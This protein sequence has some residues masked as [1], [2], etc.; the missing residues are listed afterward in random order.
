MTYKV[1]CTDGLSKR[2]VERLSKFAG[3][4]TDFRPKLTHEEL[5]DAIPA[6]DGLIVRSASKV[7]SDVIER[8]GKLKI[9]A[10]AGVG[11][12]NID[13]K[14]ATERGILVVNTPAGNTTATCELTF[15]MMLSLA[16]HVPQAAKLMTEGVWEKKKFMGT[17]L[18]RKTLGIVGMGRI[19]KEVA[20]RAKAF[21]MKI[22]A[23]D[24]YLTDDA[25]ASLGVEK[26]G[27]ERILKE[28]DY[29]TVHT[30][31]TDETRN[32]IGA[33]QFAMMK[34]TAYVVNCARGGIINERDLAEALRSNT[35]AGAALDVYTK[36]PYEDTIFRGLDNA[37]LTPHLGASTREAQD[38][39]AV[40]AAEAVGGYLTKG[41]RM[42]AVNPQVPERRA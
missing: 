30:P 18:S 2:G 8:A 24:P 20:R 13:V 37:I 17:E 32:L 41:T 14:A 31:L 16:R 15:T 21:D 10:R 40:E 9:V 36:E 25:Y 3:V 26:A 27:L 11:V 35:I 42:N 4:E 7:G 34:P 1:L 33:K 23:M 5:L 12:D 6:F 39:V 28:A 19:G 22:L 29:L 38:A